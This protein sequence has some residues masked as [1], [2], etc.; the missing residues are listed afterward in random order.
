V[1]LVWGLAAA[2][3]LGRAIVAC[4][5]TPDLTYIAS[6]A[7]IEVEGGVPGAD[8]SLEAS[9]ALADAGPSD[10][11]ADDAPIDGCGG[12][13]VD[14]GGCCTDV[15]VLCLGEA[16]AHCGDCADA[17]CG[18]SQVCCPKFAPNGSYEQTVCKKATNCT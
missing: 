14:G 18:K 16:C 4:R 12:R 8:A 15:N 3:L 6:D 5:G 1:R 9:D 17:G 10:D 11:A 7:T 2:C 13:A